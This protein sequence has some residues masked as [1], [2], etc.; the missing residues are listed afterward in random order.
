M[1]EVFIC[2][3]PL[4]YYYNKVVIPIDEEM[5]ALRIKK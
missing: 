3:V 1:I 2:D 5:E 4:E